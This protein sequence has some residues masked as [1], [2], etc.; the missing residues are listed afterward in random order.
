MSR[1]FRLNSGL[2]YS[3]AVMAVGLWGLAHWD[4]LLWQKHRERDGHKRCHLSKEA[5]G[6]V[7][8][9]CGCDAQVLWRLLPHCELYA[10]RQSPRRTA[11]ESL[12]LCGNSVER[13]HHQ[14][15]QICSIFTL[16]GL[17]EFFTV[18]FP[19]YISL[20]LFSGLKTTIFRRR[21]A[22]FAFHSVCIH[23]C[24]LTCPGLIDALSSTGSPAPHW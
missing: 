4:T 2:K 8:G 5:A 9:E 6:G 23:L 17:I 11:E 13:D 19:G 20:K 3:S 14:Q 10:V 18:I 21:L 24:F 16:N 1:P 15:P 12:S 22:H 7:G